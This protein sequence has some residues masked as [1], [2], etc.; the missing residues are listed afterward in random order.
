[1]GMGLV[2][3]VFQPLNAHVGVYLG[4]AQILVPQKFLNAAQIGARVQQV[5]GERV[6]ELVRR[7][8]RRKTGKGCCGSC[9]GCM[10]NCRS[11]RNR[12]PLRHR[13]LNRRLRLNPNRSRLPA[14]S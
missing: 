3:N 9:E 11:R 2:V 6:P 1:M 4:G 7:E 5:G 13:N 10:L 12:L 8:I 14:A